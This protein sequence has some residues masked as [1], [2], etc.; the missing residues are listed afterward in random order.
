M[1]IC[2]ATH[3]Y[4]VS[5]DNN[6]VLLHVWRRKTWKILQILCPSLWPDYTEMIWWQM[7][8][9]FS[10]LFS[11]IYLIRN[12]FSKYIW[13]FHFYGVAVMYTLMAI[14]KSWHWYLGISIVIR[15]SISVGIEK[16]QYLCFFLVLNYGISTTLLQR[17]VF[18]WF[19]LFIHL[20]VSICVL[21]KGYLNFRKH[22]S[23]GVL[24]K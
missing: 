16:I 24:I 9:L 7:L 23:I 14:W 5:G 13:L 17:F 11:F 22:P 20:N 6:L 10:T 4:I 8:C 2:E 18:L 21:E 3:I 15:T 1:K 12:A 19:P